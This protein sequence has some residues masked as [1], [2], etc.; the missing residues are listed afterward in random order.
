MKVCYCTFLS[1]T[2]VS[3]VVTIT[4]MLVM[5]SHKVIMLEARKNA[6]VQFEIFKVLYLAT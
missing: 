6:A 1:F 4:D 3:H 2:A 5:L